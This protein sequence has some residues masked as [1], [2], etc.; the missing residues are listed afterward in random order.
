[1][2]RN[3]Q[4]V[5]LTQDTSRMGAARVKH[6]EETDIRIKAWIEN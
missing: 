2:K 4:D 6:E 1:M 5:Y 3:A